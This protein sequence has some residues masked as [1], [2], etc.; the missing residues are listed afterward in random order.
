MTSVGS[1]RGVDGTV[2]GFADEMTEQN[3]SN[4]GIMTGSVS[5]NERKTSSLLCYRSSIELYDL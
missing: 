4:G 3:G 2:D 1:G 5:M